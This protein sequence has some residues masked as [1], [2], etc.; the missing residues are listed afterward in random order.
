V[1]AARP[2]GFGALVADTQ[3][4]AIPLAWWAALAALGGL[5]TGARWWQGPVA[6][7]V[8]AGAV[9]GL[10]VHTRRRFGG[11]TGDVL[12]A[13]GEIAVTAVLVVGVLA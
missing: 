12:G 2:D 13:A 1:P 3:P 6:V 5:T 7:L 8:A 10:S 4:V 11:V 9:I